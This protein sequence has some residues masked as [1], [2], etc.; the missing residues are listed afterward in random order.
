MD[1]KSKKFKRTLL[2][3]D[4]V[5]DEDDRFIFSEG[6]HDIIFY[7]IN[8]SYLCLLCYWISGYTSKPKRYIQVWYREGTKRYLKDESIMDWGVLRYRRDIDERN[9]KFW[10]KVNKF[11]EEYFNE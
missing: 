11:Y 3:R 10:D 2:L 8:L 7:S 1:I 4:F 5:V 9:K 6:D